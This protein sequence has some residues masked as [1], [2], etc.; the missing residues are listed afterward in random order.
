VSIEFSSSGKYLILT[1]MPE[2]TDLKSLINKRGIIK[3]RVTRFK[4]FLD[5]PENRVKSLEIQRRIQ[6]LQSYFREFESI[7]LQIQA[8]DA[9]QAKEEELFKFEDEFFDTISSADA[10]VK[11]I[12][13]TTQ[14]PT[15]GP[16]GTGQSPTIGRENPAVKLP[17]IHLPT[18]SGV[19]TEWITFRDSYN[20]LIN[21]N[22][23]LSDIQKFHYLR[24]SLK[25]DALSTIEHLT[26][27]NDN[28]QAAWELIQNRYENNRL[29]VQHHVRALFSLPTATPKDPKILRQILQTATSHL[30][31]LEAIKRPVDHWDDLLIYL[32]SSKFDYQTTVAWE[33]TLST[34][35]PVMKHLTDFLN[36]RCQI[37]ESLEINKINKQSQIQQRSST[38][39]S[40]QAKGQ[41]STCVICKQSHWLYQC[42]TFLSLTTNQRSS[43]IRKHN[44]C[45]NC[46]R[47]GHK[48]AQCRSGSCKKCALKHNSLLHPIETNEISQSDS[49]PTT[50][51]CTQTLFKRVILST[52]VIKVLDQKGRIQE[53]RALLD[54]GSESNFITQHAVEK[55]GCKTESIT[56]PVVGINEAVT[57]INRRTVIQ[58]QSKH[59][60]FK[61]SLQCLVIPKITQNIPLVSF[62]ATSFEIPK[63]LKLADPQF[64]ISRPIDLL[65]GNE[66]FMRLLSVGQI[67]SKTPNGPIFQKTQLGW[68]IGGTLPM[69]TAPTSVCHVSQTVEQQIQK[70]WQIEEF[71]HKTSLSADDEYC[72]KY[73]QASTRRDHSGRFIVKLP[74]KHDPPN[75]GVSKNAAINRLR[76]M[77]T[78]FKRDPQLQ[79]EYN[80]FMNE[81]LALG[82]L[83][84]V[85]VSEAVNISDYASCFLPHHA[86][87]KKDSTTTK[88]RVVFDGSCHTT[89]GKSLNDNLFSGPALQQE[90]F[91]I[92]ARFRTHQ[93]VLT[94]DIAKMYRQILV[95]CDDRNYQLIVWRKRPDLPIETFR[96][97]TVTYGLACSPYLAIR[98]LHEV[99]KVNSSQYPTVAEVIERD[100]YVDDLITGADTVDA[101]VKMRDQITT[102]LASSGFELRKFTSNHPDI[103][104]LTDQANANQTIALDTQN[105]KTFVANRVS[106]IQSLTDP[107]E[108]CH[109]PSEQNPADILSRGRTPHQLNQLSLWWHGP[110][111][112]N[113]PEHFSIKNKWNPTSVE[114]STIPEIKPSCCLLVNAADIDNSLFERFSSFSK[115][116]RV[117]A[118]ILRFVNNIRTGKRNMSRHLSCE[119]LKQAHNCII[120]VTQKQ[121]F[122]EDIHF[123]EKHGKVPQNSKLISLSPFIDDTGLLR[124][125]GRL[126]NAPLKYDQK[127]PLLLPKNHSVTNLLIESIHKQQLHGGCQ[128]TIAALRRQYWILSCRNAVRKIIFQCIK[129]FRANPKSYPQLMGDLPAP[130]V[131]PSRPFTVTGIDYAGPIVIK[132][133]YGRTTR[134]VKSYIAIFVCFA[135]RAVHIELVC[136]CST[137][138]FLN[139][140]KRFISRRGKPSHL[141]SDNATNFIGANRE[142]RNLF[143]QA[144]FNTAI[145]NHLANEQISWHFIP[146]R[147][148]HMGGLWEAAVKSTKGHLK[149]VIGNVILNYEELSTLLTMIEACLNS[150]PLTPVSNDPADF[151]ALTPGHFLIGDALTSPAEPDLAEIPCNR[152]NRYQLLMKLRQ[153]FWSRWSKEYLHQLQQRTKWTSTIDH[154]QENTLVVLRED[155][156]PPLQW[157]LG[158]IHAVHPGPDGVIR[159]VSVKSARGVF[160]RPINKVCV[161][162]MP[163]CTK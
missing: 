99:A 118:Y 86:V 8:L 116:V 53:L 148:P 6:E 44:L 112:L 45:D 59:T 71:D 140:L 93:Y 113:G 85:P 84:Q 97:K 87:F 131:T 142:L 141:Y 61:S 107:K 42:P 65:I 95:D 69:A 137:S 89:N 37:L 4:S 25:S 46:F 76:S 1:I 29:L 81:Y 91:S 40:S 35:I 2:I 31:A 101:A 150:R 56:L 157:P 10:I 12:E 18:F 41:V 27:S 30:K 149:R 80:N 129:C 119:E 128:T 83:E 100:F 22:R 75:L 43:E 33:S 160:K 94:A 134:T 21:D 3:G 136:D 66:L 124:V 156:V 23:D 47:S 103:L 54:G 159:V 139:A 50:S 52:A 78:K 123:L 115:L 152:L 110:Q 143:K 9:N 90:L 26:L 151:S 144:K 16:S 161:V 79:F 96:L 11:T 158:R 15:N 105:T 74:F 135:T 146:P 57:T 13:N 82:H 120:K 14:Q 5:V 48:A 121:A 39:V 153:H 51:Y 36:Q 68:I 64:H 147:S 133:G 125:G 58:L 104:P 77:E 19:F 138:T 126:K 24:S 102:L 108:W 60:G 17:N 122:R 49:V 98:C 62:S 132:N 7:H 117:V 111:F 34:A 28:Y 162:P 67:S 72:E 130:R 73:F 32:I 154:P 20:A 106:Q 145:E 70:F 114:N 92:L 63:N 55:L 163:E 127:H 155:N 38:H 88:L 109:V